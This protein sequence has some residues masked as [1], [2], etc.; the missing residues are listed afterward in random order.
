MCYLGKLIRTIRFPVSF[1]SKAGQRQCSNQETH[2]Q[3]YI[4]V[5]NTR[6]GNIEV[7]RKLRVVR[8]KVKEMAFSAL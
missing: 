3:Q 1:S 6:N 5:P 7:V 2:K 4:A 8:E